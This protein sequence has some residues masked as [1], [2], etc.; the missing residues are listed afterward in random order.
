MMV[1]LAHRERA[2]QQPR[3]A[4]PVEWQAQSPPADGHSQTE[5]WLGIYLN[6]T[7]LG[8]AHNRRGR[9]GDGYRIQ[10]TSRLQLPLQGQLRDVQTDATVEIDAANRLRTFDFQMRSD[11]QTMRVQGTAEPRALHLTIHTGGTTTRRRLP[12]QKPILIPDA[13]TPLLARTGRLRPNTTHTVELFDPVALAPATATI[14]V[15]ELERVAGVDGPIE[16]LR[17][18]LSYRGFRTVAWVTPEGETLKEES[19]LGWTTVRQRRETALAPPEAKPDVD[20]IASAAIPSNIPLRNPR[21]LRFLRVEL[22]GADFSTLSLATERQ[23]VERPDS[24][25]LEIRTETIDPAAVPRRPVSLPRMKPYL[26]ADVMVQSDDPEIRATAKEVVAGEPNAWEA[27]KRIGRW[28]HDALEK[29]P[30]VSVP[31]AVDVLRSRRGDCNEH[32]ILFVALARAAGIPAEIAAGIVYLEQNNSFYYHAW[33][34]VWV[35][36]WVSMDPTFG[37]EIADAAHIELTHGGLDRQAEIL[38]L[39]GRL[40]VRVIK[41][42][43]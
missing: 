24:G 7:K 42:E 21:R 12:L 26:A 32:T 36:R 34:R 6:G 22:T 4:P 3:E 40:R 27:A 11:V 38:R 16:A 13:L 18:E 43:E 20:L 30:T 25:I 35:G 8:Y 10:T 39:V 37:Q 15:G 14:E 28:V 1:L 9:H 29:S 23:R 17:T 41:A 31:S 19:A 33:P 5:E 2:A